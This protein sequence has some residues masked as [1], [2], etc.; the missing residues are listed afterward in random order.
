M[1][2]VETAFINRDLSGMI[3][4]TPLFHINR[5]FNKPETNIYAKLEWMQMGGSIKSRP[6]YR[7]IEKALQAGELDHEKEL[8]DASS[9]NTAISYAAIGAALG[10]KVTICLPENASRE[11]IT[12][13][14]AHGAKLIYTSR[15]GGTDE[16]Q[17]KAKEMKKQ[18]PERYYYADQ[19]NNPNN[20]K[21]HYHHTAEEILSQTDGAV[22]HVVVGLGTTGTAMGLGRR[23]KEFN[24]EIKLIGLQPDVAMHN[25]EGWKHL[26]TALVP[27]IYDQ[28]LI[29]AKLE[30]DSDQALLMVKAIAAKEGLMVSPSSAANLL[31]AIA[32]ANEIESGTVVTV[33]PDN[34][35]RYSEIINS[36]FP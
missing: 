33:F 27:G 7:I 5:I 15:F 11:R 3:G 34:A 31:G 35:E 10:I 4:N 25:L 19:Y 6:A 17:A 8:L 28:S 29:D 2:L 22:T 23:L 9:G 24:P 30:I 14:K 26:E 13:L 32:V 12:N 16:A 1:Q 21:A 20:W 36:I 18:D